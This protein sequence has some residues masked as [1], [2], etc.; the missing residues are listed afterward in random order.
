MDRIVKNRKNEIIEGRKSTEIDDPIRK[1]E[2][3]TAFYK[4]GQK[5]KEEIISDDM[6]KEK[7]LYNKDGTI[8][9]TQKNF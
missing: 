3:F 9:R 4:N 8:E 7:T 5:K 6:L 2:M 1:F